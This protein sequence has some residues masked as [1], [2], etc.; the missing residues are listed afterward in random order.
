MKMDIE[1]ISE[2]AALAAYD[3]LTMREKIASLAA[4]LMAC[5]ELQV[6]LPVRHIFA[7]GMY[8][9]EMF[10]PKGSI[11]VGKIH[12]QECINIC[13]Q[14]DI[15]ITTESGQMRVIAPYTVVTPPGIQR[16][17]Y[18]YQDTVWANIFL[19]D[20]TDIEKLEQELVL[21]DAEA[22]AFLDPEGKFFK[23]RLLCQ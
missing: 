3:S 14:G 17:G 18:A 22:V 12:K 21:N 9:R 23:G 4:D 2:N 7:K 15:F 16:V 5:T 11:V 1:P 6:E 13:S 19:T 10:I 8:I 20:E